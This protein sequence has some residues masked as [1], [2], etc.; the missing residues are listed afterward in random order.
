MIPLCFGSDLIAPSRGWTR[1]PPD[2]LR[3]WWQLRPT[4][5]TARRSPQLPARFG[6]RTGSSKPSPRRSKSEKGIDQVTCWRGCGRGGERGVRAVAT[7]ATARGG[8][9]Q[10]LTVLRQWALVWATTSKWA[11]QEAFAIQT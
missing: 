4:T 6:S 8:A 5:V 2:R 11:S 7:G 1:L 10:A 9:A 3:S